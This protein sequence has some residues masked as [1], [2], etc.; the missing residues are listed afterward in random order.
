[1]QFN[2]VWYLNNTHRKTGST[3]L[4][5]DVVSDDLA[6]SDSCMLI[7]SWDHF[8]AACGPDHLTL[9][10]LVVGS[11][12]MLDE[13]FT[14]H[15]SGVTQVVEHKGFIGFW[16]DDGFHDFNGQANDNGVLVGISRC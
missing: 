10:D 9:S 12:V 2:Y 7:P 11:N 4:G 3:G 1:M 14:C 15:R 13:G 8:V 6:P 5:I 16:C